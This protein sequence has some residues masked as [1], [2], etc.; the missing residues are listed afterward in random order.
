LSIFNILLSASLEKSDFF[1]G[2]ELHRNKLHI[3]FMPIH[4][5]VTT[6]L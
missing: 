4:K 5:S 3:I 1:R 2:N 6:L